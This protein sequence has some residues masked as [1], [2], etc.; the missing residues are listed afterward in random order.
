VQISELLSM[1]K[2]DKALIDFL[3]ATDMGK[4]EPKRPEEEEDEE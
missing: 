2:C 3:I 1:E 4:F